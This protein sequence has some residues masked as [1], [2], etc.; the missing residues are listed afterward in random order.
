MAKNEFYANAYELYL[1]GLSLEQVGKKIGVPRNGVW[2]AFKRRGYKMRTQKQLP[3][4]EFDGKKFTKYNS[5]YYRQTDGDRMLMHRYVWEHYNGKIDENYD[6]HHINH[7]KLDNRIE[8]LQLLSKSEHARLFST[9]KN[10]F[11]QRA[12]K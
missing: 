5:G 4:V 3:Y 2:T 12:D 1:S 7:N 6:I 10:Q 8:N 9:G 11:T